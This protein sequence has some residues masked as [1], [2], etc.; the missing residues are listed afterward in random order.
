MYQRHLFPKKPITLSYQLELEIT[1]TNTEITYSLAVGLGVH[2]FNGK[3]MFDYD[4][5]KKVSYKNS[6]ALALAD[7]KAHICQKI[8][9]DIAAT[10][11]QSDKFVHLLS[12]RFICK[13][14]NIS[15]SK[16]KSNLTINNAQT[17]LK[18]QLEDVDTRAKK[19]IA[20][21]VYIET[22][23]LLPAIDQ[24]EESFESCCTLF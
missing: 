23:K 16:L 7:K 15:K 24:R 1:L 18:K 9:D 8:I 14:M 13:E 17:I 6:Y 22:T 19:F 3:N 21:S 10:F 4:Q 20:G 11:Q 5:D 12:F 2:N